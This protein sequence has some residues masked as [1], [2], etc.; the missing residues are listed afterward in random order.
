[1]KFDCD[2]FLVFECIVEEGSF[3]KA[4]E[5][6]NRA[7]SNISYQINKLERQLGTPLLDRS[8]YRAQLTP[9]GRAILVESKRLL[10]QVSHIQHLANSYLA[11]WEANMMVVIDGA[12]PMEPMMRVLKQI[13]D[14]AV[15]TK[16]VLQVE[17][18]SGVQK[19]FQRDEA[20]LMLVK[21]YVPLPSLVSEVLPVVDNYLV[22]ARSHPL[23][24]KK[25]ASR[26]TLLAYVELTINDSSDT[27]F[28]SKAHQFGGDRVFYLSSFADKKQALL[29]G[30][31]YGWMPKFLINQELKKGELVKVDYSGGKHYQF[32][33]KLVYS[34]ER[35]LGRAGQL[36]KQLILKYYQ[37]HSQFDTHTE[38]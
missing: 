34:D 28:S 17:F 25:N 19:R 9:A 13:A 16:I 5:K 26:E 4:A 22:V 35:P 8:A 1:M 38:A 6:L 12:L 36:L 7:Q 31:G 2:S 20:S 21:D 11:G 29:M 3:A 37:D 10:A 27:A 23:A 18:L 32:T 24:N 33:P 15:P 14:Q 30:L